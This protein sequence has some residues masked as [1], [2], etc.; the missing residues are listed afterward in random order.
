MEFKEGNKHKKNKKNG[1]APKHLS[2]EELAAADLQVGDVK[3]TS[4]KIKTQVYEKK[5]ARL[6]RAGED[7]GVDQARKVSALRAASAGGR[8]AGFLVAVN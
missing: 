5:L 4:R 7:A 2:D 1:K 6:H 3:A 8:R